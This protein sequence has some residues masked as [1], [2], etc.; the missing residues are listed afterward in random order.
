MRS[1]G[2]SPESPSCTTP[3][4]TRQGRAGLRGIRDPDQR[5][6]LA[7]RRVVV[8]DV[9]R[10][11]TGAIT[12]SEEVVL[13][14][15][16]ESGRVASAGRDRRRPP[17]RAR[18]DDLRVY[19]STWPLRGRQAHRPPVLPPE[20]DAARFRC[21]R[22][23]PARARRRRRRRDRGGVRTRRLRPGACGRRLHPLRHRRACAPSTSSCSRTAAA[24]RSNTALSSTKGA[25]ARSS[26]TSCG[27]ARRRCRRRPALPSTSGA[28][29]ASSLRPACTTTPT[30][31]SSRA[32]AAHPHAVALRS[33]RS[34][35]RLRGLGRG[36]GWSSA[37]SA[38]RGRS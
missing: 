9:A 1:S 21:R 35:R 37:R 12:G 15:D 8:E 23:V 29:A 38:A 32:A 3:S 28:R 26:T 33:R 16:G 4:R 11:I 13:H 30:R 2:R 31:R 20:P 17:D 14:L 18:L 34:V 36:R 27:G 5:A 24:S 7:E 19:S 25:R 6:W 10:V 22:R